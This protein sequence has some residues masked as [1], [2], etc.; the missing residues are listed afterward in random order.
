MGF[1]VVPVLLGAMMALNHFTVSS[2]ASGFGNLLEIE[3]ATSTQSLVEQTVN[4]INQGSEIG[5]RTNEA[6]QQV[7]ASAH[8]VASLLAEIA[9]ASKEQSEGIGQVNVAVAQMDQ[10]VQQNAANAEELAASRGAFRVRRNGNGR[11]TTSGDDKG[12]LPGR[13]QVPGLGSGA[14]VAPHE[15]IPFDEDEL[16]NF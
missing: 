14:E 8:R 10:V 7:D 1:G 9:A 6:F 11:A 15:G 5:N 13:S 16:E 3:A 4:R 2:V 12:I